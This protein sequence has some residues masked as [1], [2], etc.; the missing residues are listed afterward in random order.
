[1]TPRRSTGKFKWPGWRAEGAAA[2]AEKE[3]SWSDR[4][5]AMELSWR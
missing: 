5:A 4:P 2:E 3:L 1:M